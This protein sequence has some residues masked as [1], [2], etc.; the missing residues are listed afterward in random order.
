MLVKCYVKV[1]HTIINFS[2]SN[3]EMVHLDVSQCVILIC[4]PENF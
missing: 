1:K 2:K 3:P 4:K